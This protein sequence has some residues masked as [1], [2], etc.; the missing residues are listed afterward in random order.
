MKYLA[1]FAAG[2]FIG[3]FVGGLTISLLIVEGWR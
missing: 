1:V 2:V 3:G